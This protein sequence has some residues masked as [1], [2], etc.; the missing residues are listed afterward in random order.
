M[1]GATNG[2]GFTGYNS[3]MSAAWAAAAFGNVG[4]V[5]SETLPHRA[6]DEIDRRPVKM[7]GHLLFRHYRNAVLFIAGVDLQIEMVLES[8]RILKA[9]TAAAR[10]AH[11]EH[12]VRFQF[13]R[14][15]VAF[16]LGGR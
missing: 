2:R 3:M 13:L 6:V 4:I 11:A 8:K 7:Q 12:G 16:N 1:R 14:F 9:R 10:N 15:H 5:D